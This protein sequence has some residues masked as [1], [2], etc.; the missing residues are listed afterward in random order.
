MPRLV[1]AVNPD[2]DLQPGIGILANKT[3]FG[4]Q[5]F[6]RAAANG[7]YE[8]VLSNAALRINVCSI[9]ERRCKCL[10]LS[11]YNEMK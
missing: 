1:L 2:S 11:K 7:G 3:A 9:I 8:P 5:T 6:I 4:K 10:G